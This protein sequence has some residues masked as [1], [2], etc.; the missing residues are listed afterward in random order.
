MNKNTTT[1]PIYKK[2]LPFLA[3]I[4]R[5]LLN[6]VRRIATENRFSVAHFLRE[7]LVRNLNFYEKETKNGPLSRTR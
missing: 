6:D 7:S 5:D 1:L 3:M 2:R 4:D